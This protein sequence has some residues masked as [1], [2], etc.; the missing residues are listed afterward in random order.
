M[1]GPNDTV[2]WEADPATSFVTGRSLIGFPDG[3]SP[4]TLLG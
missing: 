1:V 3:Q 4:C 2:P